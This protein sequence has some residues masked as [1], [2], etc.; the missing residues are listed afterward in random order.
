V[1]E[2]TTVNPDGSVYYKAGYWN[3]LE[4]VREY[5]NRR[6][7]D[8]PALD[9]SRHLLKWRG[10]P[11]AKALILN[12]G[13]GWVERDLLTVGVVKEAV[14]IDFIDDLLDTARAAAANDDLPL[15]Y[16]QMDTNTAQFPEGDYDLVVNFAAAHH[17]ARLDRVFRRVAELLP[18]DGVFV[19]WDYVGAHRN[20][21]PTE[22]WEAVWETNQRLPEDMR[23]DLSYPHVPTMIYGDPT[24]AV[25]SELIVSTM[26]RYFDTVY[27]RGVGGA[28]AYPLLTFNEPM[29]SRDPEQIV[30]LV[31]TILEADAEY[32]DRDPESN[33][34]FAYLIAQPNKAALTN[35]A[36]LT[37]W[38]REEDEREAAAARNDGAYYARTFLGDVYQKH[39]AVRDELIA[40]TAE[41]Q[42]AVAA[43]DAASAAAAAAA[44]KAEALA[45]RPLRANPALRAAVAKVPG[46]RPVYRWLRAVYHRLR[47]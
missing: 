2:A 31:G 4:Q 12:C 8:D 28:L 35:T 27:Y 39:H 41:L 22:Q 17:I 32:T 3:Q 37:E 36:Q 23:Q 1:S 5:L 11:F 38:A 25:H 10:G 44:A 16:Y 40:R 13:N 42:A 9:W 6:A 29:L 47:D 21:Y 7:T 45:R 26:R 18:D 24:E 43:A 19:S 20:Q 30:D 34:L 15:R 33:T 14:G 46:A